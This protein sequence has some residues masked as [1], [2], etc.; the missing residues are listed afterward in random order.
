[1]K[2]PERGALDR[3]ADC[4]PQNQPEHS[5]AEVEEARMTD[6]EIPE[7]TGT[8]NPEH[9]PLIR[10][11]A[12]LKVPATVVPVRPPPPPGVSLRGLWL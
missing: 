4:P 6:D 8:E 7:E 3:L 11:R 5:E 10:E 9:Q 12:P 1:M 2:D